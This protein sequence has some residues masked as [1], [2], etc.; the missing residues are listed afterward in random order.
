[1]QNKVKLS[2]IS[3]L[4]ST[5]FFSNSYAAG[6]MKPGLWEM[7]M[8]SDAMQAMPQIP[9]EQ[10]AKMKAMGVEIP[11]MQ[12]GAIIHKVCVSK[13]MAE[14]DQPQVTQNNHSMCKPQNMNQSGN[15]YTMDLICDSPELK[16]I[17]TVRGIFN[18]SEN[19]RSVYDFKGTSRNRPISQHMETT[20]KWLS[21]DCGD[22]K[23]VSNFQK[24]K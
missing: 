5:F 3:L 22:V 23:P 17:G 19:I 18:G 20:G 16:G 21:A 1:M 14:Q 8:R 2:L 11:N 10:R 12:G 13:E 6:K 4:L 15:G 24:K 7:S 9:P